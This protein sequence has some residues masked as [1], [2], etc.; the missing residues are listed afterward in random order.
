[1]AHL[2]IRNLTG[3]DVD[4]VRV[5]PPDPAEPAVDFG[6]LRAGAVSSP[7]PVPGARR[8]AHVD[9]TTREESYTLQPYDFVGEQPLPAGEYTYRI[10]LSGDRLTLELEED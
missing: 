2:R 4:N 10:G 8:F 6:P 5:H 3:A 1:M 7:R 9:V